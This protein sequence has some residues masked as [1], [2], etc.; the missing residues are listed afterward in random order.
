MVLNGGQGVM[1]VN[2]KPNGVMPPWKDVLSDDEIANILTFV[3]QS[4]E[5]GNAGSEVT[6]EM[7]KAVR[8]KTASRAAAWTPAELE[9]VPVTE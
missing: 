9:K 5:W 1:T 8:E 6:P 2:G 4:P 3:R 7:V